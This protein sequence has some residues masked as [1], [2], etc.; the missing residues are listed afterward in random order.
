MHLIY[1]FSDRAEECVRLAQRTT[2]AHD[3]EL[4]MGLA[5]AWYG[6][7]DAG[8]GVPHSEQTGVH[9]RRISGKSPDDSTR[10]AV[11]FEGH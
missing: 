10:V 3:W 9:A 5:W 11:S 1:D 6:M 8:G 4:F 2:S 7:A